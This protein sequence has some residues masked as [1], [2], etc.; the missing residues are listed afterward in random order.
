MGQIE[1]SI[2]RDNP[3]VAYGRTL[4]EAIGNLALC[5]RYYGLSGVRKKKVKIFPIPEYV[6]YVI[7]GS[8]TQIIR[9]DINNNLYRVY[10]EI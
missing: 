2:I 6:Y 1:S 8:E 4:E 3:F 9:I 10:V 5:L 7:N